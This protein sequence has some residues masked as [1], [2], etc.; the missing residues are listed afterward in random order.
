MKVLVLSICTKEHAYFIK[1]VCEAF[2][3]TAVVK[4]GGPDPDPAHLPRQAEVARPLALRIKDA[5]VDRIGT[6]RRHSLERQLFRSGEDPSIAITLQVSNPNSPAAQAQIR[7]HKPDVV[8]VFGAPILNADALSIGTRAT[9]N[10]HLGIAPKYRGNNT[11]FWALK[12]L[13]FDHVGA[14]LHHIAPGVDTGNILAEA[15]PALSRWSNDIDATAGAIRLISS[16]TVDYL[17]CVQTLGKSPAGTPQSGESRN[18]RAADRTWQ[19]VLSYVLRRMLPGG[20]PK[21]REG[22]VVRHY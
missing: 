10:I 14:C 12:A 5:L 9:V 21:P 3:E 4:I 22:R 13:D 11:I 1:R 2:P 7:A 6:A 15:L 19:A 17:N 20:R 16:A 8:V 18:Y